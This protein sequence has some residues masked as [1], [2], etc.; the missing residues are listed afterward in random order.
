MRLTRQRDPESFT[1]LPNWQN[2][3]HS[4]GTW[5]DYDGD[6][7]YS[8]LGIELTWNGVGY[9]MSTTEQA[10]HEPGIGS[11]DYAADAASYRHGDRIGSTR[12]ITGPTTLA[13]PTVAEVTGRIVYTAFGE[14]VWS[15][16]T[17]GT[18]YQYAGAW[19][20]QSDLYEDAGANAL[21]SSLFPAPFIHV[22]HRWYDPSTGRFLQRDPIGIA[23][24]ANVYAYSHSSPINFIDDEGLN[25]K[26]WWQQKKGPRGQWGPKKW[27]Y[28]KWN[29]T[30]L[31]AKLCL[32]YY[33]AD[34]VAG[35]AH[36][37]FG[38]PYESPDEIVVDICILQAQALIQD[39]Y[40]PPNRPLSDFDL[41]GAGKSRGP[42]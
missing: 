29:P 12:A 14:R 5:H 22:G 20:Y 41:L 30:T 10:A 23:G 19:G 33:L 13:V 15:D 11:F 24:G 21:P 28:R 39:L 1:A 31:S 2:S 40:I 25:P 6:E 27:I 42:W 7:I 38:L 26:D 18:R 4:G 16:G 32:A 8:D 37:L 36:R 34:K 9:D 35:R 17:V 3:V